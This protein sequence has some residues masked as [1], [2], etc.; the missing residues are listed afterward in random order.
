[1]RLIWK[2][3][4]F[5]YRILVFGLLASISNHLLFWT[6]GI[7]YGKGLVVNGFLGIR[8]EKPKTIILG[9]NV[10]INSGSFF[11]PIGRN[12]QTRLITYG[13]ANITLGSN[14][15]LSSSVLVASKSIVIGD[16]VK[17]GGNVVMYDSDF[18]SL[19][20]K[21]RSALPEDLSDVSHKSIEVGDD[22]F[23]GAHST[24]LKGT[25][26]GARSIIGAGSVVSGNIPSDQIWAGNPATY[27]RDIS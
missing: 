13:N 6:H 21:K 3:A 22:V 27:V 18:H 26:V 8:C 20:Y 7:K 15:G 12:Q 1:M 19:D 25:S 10:K 9:D 14:V 4:L 17:I 16:N 24:I 2:G 23:I 5:I 11:N